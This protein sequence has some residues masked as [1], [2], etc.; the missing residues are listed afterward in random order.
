[1]CAVVD[2]SA[3]AAETGDTVDLETMLNPRELVDSPYPQSPPPAAEASSAAGSDATATAASSA[4]AAGS[5][6][7][8]A[9]DAATAVEDDDDSSSVVIDDDVVVVN[10]AEEQQDDAV[11]PTEVPAPP[12]PSNRPAFL[13]ALVDG[14]AVAPDNTPPSSAGSPFRF[15][16]RHFTYARSALGRTGSG[17]LDLGDDSVEV[18]VYTSEDSLQTVKVPKVV[19]AAQLVRVVSP[20][21]ADTVDLV[22]QLDLGA[23][24]PTGTSPLPPHA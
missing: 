10:D 13:V 23:G 3:R 1:M 14:G 17:S 15:Q 12:T 8:S 16:P 24:L 2:Q 22:E 20:D 6:C 4:D 7:D 19:T 11:V 21:V 18:T 9:S 5:K